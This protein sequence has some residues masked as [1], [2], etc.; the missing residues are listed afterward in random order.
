MTDYECNMLGLIQRYESHGRNTM[1]YVGTRQ[2]LS[3]LAARGYTA[4]GY[5]QILN[6]NWRKLAPRLGITAPNAM[7]GTL[8]EQ[9][10]VALALLRAAG[11]RPK[12][13]APFNPALRAAIAR[14][15][16]APAG[17]ITAKDPAAL[18]PRLVKGIDGKEGIDLGNGTM[19][20]PDGS[21]RSITRGSGFT[22]PDAAPSGL[23]GGGGGRADLHAVAERFHAA[24]ERMENAGFHGRVDVALSGGGGRVTGLRTK[25][26]GMS[27]DMGVS[28]PG[29]K[30]SDDDWA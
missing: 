4:Q 3:P 18:E 12:D 27:A 7:A 15:E 14:G 9:T 23:R 2:G 11:G 24:A 20:M 6:S 17:R 13:W 8:E 26:L 19:R 21:I 5:F 29:A 1:N 10:R 28:M 30:E 16:R 25:G 22:V